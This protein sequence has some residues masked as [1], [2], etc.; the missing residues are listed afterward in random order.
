MA[1]AAMLALAAPADAL[2]RLHVDA[3][4]MRVDRN[5]VAIG[6]V[7][8]LAIRARLRE[9]VAAL[10]ELVI[11][12]VGALQLEGDE[13]H[14]THSPAG[15]D[16]VETLTLEATASGRYTLRG[17]YVDAID[18]RTGKPTRFSA[19]PVTIVVDNPGGLNYA[20]PA[21]I[22]RALLGVVLALLAIVV[23]AAVLLAL[24]KARRARERPVVTV[25]GPIVAAAPA[26]RT[27]RDEVAEALGAFR[28]TPE[29]PALLRLRAALFAAA[30]AKAGATLRDAL[31]AG[32]DER[33]RVALIAAERTAFGPAYVREAAAA[34]LV[35]ATEVWLS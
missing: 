15:T 20:G 12:D 3:L 16:I 34:E 2:R 24:V 32:A 11:P 10:D 29:T 21:A 7:F 25:S 13:R 5:H 19:D 1:A 14:V 35:R 27:P 30:G 33:L 22:W 9:R 28:R 8:H 18:A 23:A 17:A 26:P 31:R 6:Q 4:A